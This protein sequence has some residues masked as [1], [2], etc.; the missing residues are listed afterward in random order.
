MSSMGYGGEEEERRGSCTGVSK[1]EE[2]EMCM[3]VCVRVDERPGVEGGEGE[4]IMRTRRIRK[5]RRND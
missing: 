1:R 2:K 3:C 4:G 5:R